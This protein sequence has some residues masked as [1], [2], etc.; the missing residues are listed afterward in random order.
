VPADPLDPG[1]A[2]RPG[3]VHRID[4]DTSGLLVV[5]KN[6]VARED[7]KRQLQAHSVERR[8]RALTIGVPKSDTFRTVHGRDPRSRLRF[9]SKLREGKSAIT[10]LLLLEALAGAR[11]A[12]VECRLQTGRTHQ[13]RVH[14]LECAKTPLLGDSLYRGPTLLPKELAPAAERIGRQALHAMVLGFDHPRT[15]LRLRF[16]A[17]LPDDFAGALALLRALT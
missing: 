15:K 11:A 14:L 7:L 1:G 9:T 5:A 3:I 4:K 17:P 13:I 12:Y 16:E 2:L 10:E 8:Y 6:P